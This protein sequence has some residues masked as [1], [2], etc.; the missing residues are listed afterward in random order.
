[1]KKKNLWIAA[2]SLLMP[3]L[4]FSQEDDATKL[5]A[6]KDFMLEINIRPFGNTDAS[7]FESLQTKYWL[8]NRVAMRLGLQ[9][10]YKRN[11]TTGDDYSADANLKPNL[12]EKSF[13]YGVRPGIEYRILPNSKIS[14][15]VGL[16]FSYMN[17]MSSAN[18]EEYVELY[19]HSTGQTT[20]HKIETQV[21]G[22]WRNIE[23]VYYS[24]YYGHGWYSITS[25]DK[26]QS[27]TSYGLNL[28]FGTDFFCI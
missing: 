24:N 8:S 9:F 18:Y 4:T 1:M 3:L 28:L 10:A 25:Y 15:Y 19:D 14:P 11:S 23:N 6:K 21:E 20:Y 27:F 17:K 26:E 12:L 16:E 22:A 7:A 5:P 13:F 2:L